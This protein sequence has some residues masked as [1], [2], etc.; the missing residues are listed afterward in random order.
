MSPAQMMLC[1]WVA[2]LS[3]LSVIL[4]AADKASAI[5]H[6][7]RVPELTLFLAAGLGGSAVMYLT[8]LLIRHKT[9]HLK[10]MLGLPIIM[11]MQ[12]PVVIFL[13][14]L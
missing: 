7:R 10:F 2:V 9:K 14:R 1:G 12:I 13:W 11:L 6:G 5:R 3:I 8:M 4:T